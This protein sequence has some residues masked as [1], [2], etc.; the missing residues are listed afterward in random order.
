MLSR[1]AHALQLRLEGRQVLLRIH[2]L[3]FENA[4]LPDVANAAASSSPNILG[5]SLAAMAAPTPSARARPI[6]KISRTKN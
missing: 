3:H 5:G 4:G 1:N 6:V 2:S